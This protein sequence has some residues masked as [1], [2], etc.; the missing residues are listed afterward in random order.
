[1]PNLPTVL[2]GLVVLALFVAVVARGVYNR[3]RGKS[4][5]SCGC[6]DCPGKSLCHP[7]KK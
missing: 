3:K 6:G 1:M 4:G 7:E 2:V 5:C